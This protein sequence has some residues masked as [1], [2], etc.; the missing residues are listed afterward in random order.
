ML[1]GEIYLSLGINICVRFQVPLFSSQCTL[2]LSRNRL[3]FAELPFYFPEF[4]FNFPEVPF[5]FLK[6]PFC[7]PEMPFCFPEV[8][9]ISQKSPIFFQNCLLPIYLLCVTDCT[10]SLT[11]SELLREII[12]VLLLFCFLLQWCN[13]KDSNTSIPVWAPKLCR[14]KKEMSFFTLTFSITG[15]ISSFSFF[16]F[17]F[18]RKHS[19]VHCKS[20]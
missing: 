5:S 2:L 18:S 8:S 12:L 9:F 20:F 14:P 13:Q 7:F 11:C 17:F 15:Y 19:L 1:L 10:F 6:L 16:F 4:I 3:L